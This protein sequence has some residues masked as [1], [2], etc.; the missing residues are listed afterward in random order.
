MRHLDD[1]NGDIKRFLDSYMLK[2]LNFNRDDI[3]YLETVF[4][5]TIE[6]CF[7]IYEENL[8]KPFDIKIMI[9]VKIS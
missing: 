5:Q 7:S 4:N 9:G 6:L 2:A 3:N 8:F 1:F